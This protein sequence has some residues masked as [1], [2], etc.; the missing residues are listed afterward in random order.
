MG[1]GR[2]Q[3]GKIYLGCHVHVDTL[4]SRRIQPEDG[5]CGCDNQWTC[6][7]VLTRKGRRGCR[8][9]RGISAA[10]YT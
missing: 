1:T 4:V 7:Y 2:V 10:I 9:V 5:G 8:M 3:T 6:V